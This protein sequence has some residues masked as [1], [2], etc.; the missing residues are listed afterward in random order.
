MAA[1]APSR[2]APRLS[3]TDIDADVVGDVR[4]RAV[5]DDR[6]V[7]VSE[8]G[9]WTFLSA[10][11]L[12]AFLGGTVARDSE[13]WGTLSRHHLLKGELDPGEAARRYHTRLSFLDHGPQRHVLVVTERDRG[14]GPDDG[15]DMAAETAERALDCAF[16]STAPSLDIH[17]VGG[18]PLEASGRLRHAVEY[19]NDKNRLARKDVTFWLETDLVGLD[20]ET[21]AWIASRGIRIV[22]LASDALLAGEDEEVARSILALHGSWR[23]AGHEGRIHLRVQVQP[24]HLASME[25]IADRA[26]ELGAEVLD[27]ELGRSYPGLELGCG[28]D[29]AAYIDGYSR[30]LDRL[31]ERAAAG[32]TTRER[33]AATLLAR[34]LGG[35]PGR[36]VHWRSPSVDGLGELAYHVD[37][38]VFTSEE[39]RRIGDEGDDLF[40][41]GELRFLG[42]HD[43]ITSETLRAIVLASVLDGLPGWTSS[44]YK[45][46]A[47]HDAARAYGETGSLQGRAGES[48]SSRA[49][50]G[51]LDHL[52]V[53]LATGPP[54]CRES[55]EAWAAAAA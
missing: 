43:M 15:E 9:D 17:F 23:D 50:V 33:T 10:A 29:V 55:F 13:L 35:S 24:H 21:R 19:A 5:S 22:V 14:E 47:G 4:W 25:A 46:F 26:V 7:V 54:A 16:M 41:L 28:Y 3:L 34:I 1:S 31:L 52:F 30:A 36:D 27:L 6:F 2:V 38:R 40:E 44:A 32:A 48:P 8:L 53:R 39:G 20:D 42:Y 18:E 49:L 37:G 45:P 11:E 12:E 51:I